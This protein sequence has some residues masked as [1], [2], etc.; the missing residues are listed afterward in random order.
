[1][2]I[3]NLNHE[4]THV[5]KISISHYKHNN[6]QKV[7]LL[8]WYSISIATKIIKKIQSKSIS[9]AHPVSDLDT[10]LTRLQHDTTTT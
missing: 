1:M 5:L 9:N 8:S 7:I 3:K 6:I 10:Y 2:K 4:R